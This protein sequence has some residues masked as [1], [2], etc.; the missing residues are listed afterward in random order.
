MQDENDVD[1]RPKIV[2]REVPGEF[3]VDDFM[4]RYSDYLDAAISG[5]ND[6]GSFPL[7][8]L[9]ICGFALFGVGFLTIL[10]GPETVQYSRATGPTFFQYLQLYPG[11]IASLG[12]L[13]AHFGSYIAARG[14]TVLQTPEQFLSAHYELE[15]PGGSKG[16]RLFSTVHIDSGTFKALERP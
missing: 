4:D 14:N 7:R 9:S 12:L 15:F 10:L 16:P 2:V 6:A 8:F 5:Q 1:K 11:P 13:I 3:V